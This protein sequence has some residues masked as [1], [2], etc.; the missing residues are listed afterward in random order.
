MKSENNYEIPS[1]APL[2]RFIAPYGLD[3]SNG[4]NRREAEYK[5]IEANTDIEAVKEWI[6]SLTEVS[7]DTAFSYRNAVEKLLNW[8]CFT[9]GKALSSLDNADLHE[10]VEFLAAPFPTS[11]WICR[12]RVPR[13]SQDWRPFAGPLSQA[14]VR[15]VISAICSLFTWLTISGYALMPS[16][17]R[18]RTVRKG[19]AMNGLNAYISAVSMPRTLSQ[20]AWSWVKEALIADV[21]FRTRFVIELMYFANLKVEEVRKLR[22]ADCIAPS[23]RCL[24]WRLQVDSMTNRLRCVYLV[25]PLGHSLQQLFEMQFLLPSTSLRAPEFRQKSELLFESGQWMGPAIKRVLKKSADLASAGGDTQVAKEIVQAK[26]TYFRGAFESHSGHDPAFILGLVANARGCRTLIAKYLLYEI[27]EDD[28][29]NAAW[30]RLAGH[31]QLYS[32]RLS[33]VSETSPTTLA[34]ARKSS[35]LRFL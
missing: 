24:A 23:A 11:A 12:G 25:P 5:S 28:A 27:L 26:L 30:K 35:Q 32:E 4:I 22:Q 9:R 15:L 18:A 20:K 34:R 33:Q 7:K 31:W 19:R 13:E 14:S 1:I 16:I 10:F 8:S 21:P 29:I 6:L 3:G 2:E 17:S